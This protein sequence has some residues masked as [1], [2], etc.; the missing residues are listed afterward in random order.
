MLIGDLSRVISHAASRGAASAPYAMTPPTTGSSL[1]SSLSSSSND[2]PEFRELV[3]AADEARQ[4]YSD[5]TCEVG[6]QEHCLNIVEVAL[7]TLERE[8]AAVQVATADA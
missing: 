2:Q 5:A 4:P 8:T 1:S 3:Q 7:A 6:Q